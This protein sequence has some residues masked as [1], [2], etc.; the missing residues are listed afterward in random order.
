MSRDNSKAMLEQEE[1]V[2]AIGE[3]TVC[4]TIRT[5]SALGAIL[6]AFNQIARKHGAEEHSPQEWCELE[7][8]NALTARKRAWEYSAKTQSNKA[9]AEEMRVISKLFTVPAP[10]APKYMERLQARFE[11]EQT[12]RAKYGVQ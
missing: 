6:L 3:D 1:I 7:L 8:Q 12:C 11:A 2:N 10:D 9:F 5:G 4:V